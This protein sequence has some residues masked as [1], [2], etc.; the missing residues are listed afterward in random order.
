MSAAIFS[1]HAS[2][3]ESLCSSTMSQGSRGHGTDGEELVLTRC[4][5]LW[6]GVGKA[7]VLKNIYNMKEFGEDPVPETVLVTP[8]LIGT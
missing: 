2:H 1:I 4:T 7:E 6:G 5:P 3:H 8:L